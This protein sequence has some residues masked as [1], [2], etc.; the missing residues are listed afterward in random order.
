MSM[1]RL[2]YTGSRRQSFTENG[3]GE[4]E[5]GAEFEVPEDQAERYLRRGDIEDATP[6]PGRK[7]RTA[8]P[9]VTEGAGTARDG[10]ADTSDAGAGEDC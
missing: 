8:K 5:A 10:E 3:V 7:P 9:E 1:R 2:R 6:K 4:V